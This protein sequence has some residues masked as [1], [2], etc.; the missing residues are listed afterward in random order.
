MR[1]KGKPFVVYRGGPGGFVI[2]P[3][4]LMGWTQFGVWL[5]LLGLLVVWFASHI[6]VHDEG[7]DY[8]AGLFLFTIGLLA[9]LAGGIW[10]MV[11]RAKVVEVGEMRRDRQRARRREQIR[12]RRG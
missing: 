5:G 6:R 11:A 12:Q 10:W 8:L 7:A 3:R 1:D 9:W 2:V 4:G